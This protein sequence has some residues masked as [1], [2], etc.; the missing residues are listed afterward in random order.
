MPL[1]GVNIDHVATLR[2]QRRGRIPDVG[3]AARCCEGAGADSVVVH[4]RE[5]RRHIQDEDVRELRRS[6]RTR[7]NLEMS[8]A[9][10]IVDFALQVKPDQATLVPEKRQ[11]LT[12]EGGLDVVRFASRVAR[13]TG[14]LV[15]AGIDVSL[16]IEPSARQ[17]R[18]ASAAGA[19]V[20]ELHTGSYALAAAPRQR[21]D[22]LE[23][24]RGACAL[25][26][27]LGMVVN[28]GHGLDYDNVRPIAEMD[29]MHELNIGYAIIC[30]AIFTGL[31]EAVRQMRALL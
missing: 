3:A 31:E 28:A 11:E 26:R 22:E 14:R 25:G 16:F 2:Q 29:G 9:P 4:L 10:S 8:L 18:A 5:D 23:R 30:R 6:L 17:V 7:L 21:R 13:A 20:I 19:T 24:I 12:T 1:L 27:R 15:K